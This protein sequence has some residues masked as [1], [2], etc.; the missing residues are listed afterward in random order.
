[1]RAASPK[2][3]ILLMGVLPRGP[4]GDPLRAQV[5]ELNAALA[6][7]AGGA[8]NVEFLD[9]GARFLAADGSIPVEIMNDGV[10]PTERGYRI[11]A[12]AIEPVVQRV[13]GRPAGA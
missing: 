13:L 10:H 3:R 1:V 9:I 4:A 2:S 12:D 6:A 5:R 11:W 8:P 7:W